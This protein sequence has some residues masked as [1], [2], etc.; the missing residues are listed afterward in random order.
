MVSRSTAFVCVWKLI[1]SSRLFAC[2]KGVGDRFHKDKPPT[3]KRQ[4]SV[5]YSQLMQVRV[6]GGIGGS[7]KARHE[8]MTT[9][10]DNGGRWM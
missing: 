5:L 9:S 4:P 1:P 6:A 10:L 7:S 2:V 8:G 3:L